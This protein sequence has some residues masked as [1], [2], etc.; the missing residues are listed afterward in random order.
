NALRECGLLVLVYTRRAAMDE[1]IATACR[2]ASDSSIPVLT[3]SFED[4][5]EPGPQLRSYVSTELWFDCEDTPFE[6]QSAVILT[7]IEKLL[8]TGGAVRAEAQM[9]PAEEDPYP[10]MGSLDERPGMFC[11]QCGEDNPDFLPHCRR[12]GGTML[13][14]MGSGLTFR[15]CPVCSSGNPAF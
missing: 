13:I 2:I 5:L 11:N 14:D 8:P 9:P 3:L 12:C 15:A 7:L 4:D 6:Q 1:E 10:M